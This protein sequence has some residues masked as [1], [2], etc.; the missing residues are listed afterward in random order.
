MFYEK[1]DLTVMVKTIPPIATKQTITSRLNLFN[2]IKKKKPRHVNVT[3]EIQVLTWDRQK[4]AVYRRKKPLS[5]SYELNDYFV[6]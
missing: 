6:R 5:C 4:I 1:K 2:I 3:L